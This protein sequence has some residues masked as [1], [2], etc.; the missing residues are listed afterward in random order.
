MN[1]CIWFLTLSAVAAFGQDTAPAFRPPAQMGWSVVAGF[2][3]G[4]TAITGAPY[5]AEIVSEDVQTLVDGTHITRKSTSRVYRDSA[6]RTRTERPMGPP[7]IEP[8]DAPVMIEISDPVAHVHYFLNPTDKTAQK[9]STRPREALPVSQERTA[10]FTREDRAPQPSQAADSE[11][12]KMTEEKL[13][14]QT[15][16]GLLVAGTR[17]TITWPV[18]S[19]MG[20]DRPITSVTETWSSP[21]LNI[22]VLHKR[23]DPRSGE[24]TWKLTNISRAEPDPSLFQPPADYTVKEQDWEGLRH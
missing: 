1:R 4:G 7:G 24:N 21:E 16:E 6:G 13:G 18:N 3:D 23:S 12:P 10:F 15:I 11:P 5:S 14:T 20:N 9:Q 17:H 19:S 22:V 2:G 8:P